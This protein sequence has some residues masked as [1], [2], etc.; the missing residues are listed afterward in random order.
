MSYDTW[1]DEDRATLVRLYH[2]LHWMYGEFKHEL[3]A[4]PVET[5]RIV[6]SWGTNAFG[7]YDEWREAVEGGDD[8]EL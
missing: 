3:H 2:D 5:C 7:G 4:A 8:E 1:T 6:E